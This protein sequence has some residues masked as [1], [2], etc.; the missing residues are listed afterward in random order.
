MVLENQR[1]AWMPEEQS[2]VKEKDL[3][4]FLPPS[5]FYDILSYKVTGR[6]NVSILMQKKALVLDWRN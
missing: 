1:Y 5:N 4:L 6:N 2:L 3:G